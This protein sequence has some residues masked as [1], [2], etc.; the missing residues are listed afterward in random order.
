M[1]IVLEY[2]SYNDITVC[3][4]KRGYALFFRSLEQA[5]NYGMLHTTRYQAV[6]TTL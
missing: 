1:W 6:K 5:N 2:N 3:T 4:D